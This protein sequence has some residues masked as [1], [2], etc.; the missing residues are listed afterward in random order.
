MWS[1]C[2]QC[3]GEND[4]LTLA[5]LLHLGWMYQETGHLLEA[6][7]TLRDAYKRLC[8]LLGPRHSQT[9]STQGNLAL[10]YS[11]VDNKPIAIY[12]FEAAFKALLETQ[13]AD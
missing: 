9:L 2:L 5:F 10:V 11:K 3:L 6:E 4:K 12:H 7:Q 1:E 13:G 8:T